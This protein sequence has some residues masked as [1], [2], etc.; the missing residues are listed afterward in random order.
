[1]PTPVRT[2]RINNNDDTVRFSAMLAE[3]RKA[4]RQGDPLAEVETDKAN[5]TVEA[6]RDGYVLGY[7]AEVGATL[8]VGSILL[9][10]GESA[11]EAMPNSATGTAPALGGAGGAE[12]TLKALMLLSQYGLTASEVPAAGER[13]TAQDVENWAGGRQLGRV[14]EARS[15]AAGERMRLPLAAGKKEKLTA[16]E[17]G[18][19]RTVMWSNEAVPGYVEV[20]YDPAAWVQCAAA[21]QKRHK[22][23]QDPLLPLMAYQLV[24]RAA[25]EPR[26]NA[27]IIGDERFQYS[28][29]NLGFTVQTAEALRLVTVEDAASL[30]AVEFVRRLFT[31]QMNAMK[32]RLKANESSGATIGF[33][34][35]A[36]WG[37]TRHIPVLPPYTALMVA[38]AAA[39]G[40]LAALAATY[41]HRVMAGGDAARELNLLI[42]PVEED[43]Q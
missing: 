12:P 29:V 22:L 14:R 38:H 26:I 7:N 16:A 35:M 39:V 40:G 33:T 21:F 36:R 2:P 1:M 27:T 42:H 31:L 34:S 23:I 18:M 13:L 3:P 19:L 24:R 6:E 11:D 43:F 25:S 28:H 17:H 20:S 37:V 9:W 4:V 10:L 5:F 41:D 30:E 15:G 32:N 8:D